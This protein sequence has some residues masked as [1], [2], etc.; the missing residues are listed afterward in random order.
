[1]AEAQSIPKPF[2]CEGSG[3]IRYEVRVGRRGTEYESEA[4]A[5][6][7]ALELVFRGSVVKLITWAVENGV[8]RS[9]SLET[10]S[11]KRLRYVCF[12][13]IS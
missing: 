6:S 7:A 1:M 2:L 9:R 8:Y 11:L 5:R 13:I 12:D 4:E 3:T 10:G